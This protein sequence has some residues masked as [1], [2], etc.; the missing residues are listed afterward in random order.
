[1]MDPSGSQPDQRFLLR[2][3]GLGTEFVA[4]MLGCV[5]LGWWLDSRYGWSPWGVLVGSIVGLVGS[6]T[7]LIRRALQ[8]QR[9]AEA[10][11]RGPK[12]PG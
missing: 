1:M 12:R 11:R 2:Y 5:A 7:N 9:A 10:R 8:M 6:M 4:G 3:A